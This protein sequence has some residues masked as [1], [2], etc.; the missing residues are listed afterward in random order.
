VQLTQVLSDIA[1]LTGLAIIRAIVAGER[2]PVTLAQLADPR[3]HSSQEQIAKALT[4]NY[5]TEHVFALQQSLALYD[6][7]SGQLVECDR[8]LERQYAATK[9][10]F[11]PDDPQHPLGPDPKRQS[12]RRNGPHFDV[13]TPLFKRVGVDL[14]AV[15][16]FDES[17]AQTL[18]AEIGTQME[19]F[20]T[21]K[22]FCSWLGLAP[23]N[24]ITGGKV[25]RRHTLPTHNR[26]AQA[27][28]M[29]AQAAGN[30]HSAMGD[31]FRRMRARVGPKEAVTATAH[32]LARIVYHMLKHRQSYNPLTPEAYTEQ[33]RQRELK[34]LTRRAAKLGLT[35]QAQPAG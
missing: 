21:V 29:A 18:L 17:T 7:Y 11:D 14:T 6:A 32:K 31:Y 10:R 13:R 24:D 20:P 35:L 25:V 8:Q 2:N 12:R 4:G 19:R 30:S 27:L 9:P 26:A 5:R 23:H 34:S 1:G 28:R 33:L 16:G 3:C 15:D 22:H